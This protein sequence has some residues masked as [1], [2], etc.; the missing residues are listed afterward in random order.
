MDNYPQFQIQ[1]PNSTTILVLGILSIV[2]C[3]FFGIIF[4]IITL[5]MASKANALYYSNTQL[6]SVTSLNNVKVGK[7]CA[8]IGLILSGLA[9]FYYVA[10]I[11]FMGRAMTDMP[12][13][14]ITL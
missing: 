14:N 13:D 9:T 2:I 6:Y 8:I 10:M 7:I 4:G 1:L 5:V 11:A 12:F 3:C